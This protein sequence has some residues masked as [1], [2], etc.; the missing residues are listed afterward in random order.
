V[1]RR[2]LDQ[3]Q[4][5]VDDALQ[6]PEDLPELDVLHRFVAQTSDHEVMFRHDF[7]RRCDLV[8]DLSRFFFRLL[9]SLLLFLL[10]PPRGFLR[11][12]DAV[13]RPLASEFS[14]AS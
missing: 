6:R 14:T 1:Q 10:F 3:R 12:G 13:S 2:H 8:Q 5:N 9:L 11:G 4:G 7:D